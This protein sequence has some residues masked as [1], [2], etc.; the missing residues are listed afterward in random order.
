MVSGQAPPSTAVYI[1]SDLLFVSRAV[2]V[3]EAKSPLFERS[4]RYEIGYA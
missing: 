4:R 1:G 3:V 2:A